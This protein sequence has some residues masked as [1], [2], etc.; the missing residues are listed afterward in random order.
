MVWLGLDCLTTNLILEIV[1]CAIHLCLPKG[2][3]MFGMKLK[4]N[5]LNYLKLET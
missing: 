1:L 5:E 4:I 2:E 3:K